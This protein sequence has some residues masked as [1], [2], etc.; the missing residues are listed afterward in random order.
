MICSRRGNLRRASSEFIL[1]AFSM[2]C[3]RWTGSAGES[4]KL[5]SAAWKRG[6][7][8][9][10]DVAFRFL[11]TARPLTV[12]ALL[13]RTQELVAEVGQRHVGLHH[14]AVLHAVLRV[15][16][17]LLVGLPGSIAEQGQRLQLQSDLHFLQGI[18]KKW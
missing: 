11:P 8:V 2:L 14:T 13:L 1:K 6:E 5:V 9:N 3:T 15:G 4:G 10:G 17:E 7:E 12:A 16:L 18:K